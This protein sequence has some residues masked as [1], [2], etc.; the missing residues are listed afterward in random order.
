MKKFIGK[1]VTGKVVSVHSGSNKDL[2][3]EA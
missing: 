1:T 3:K 2:S